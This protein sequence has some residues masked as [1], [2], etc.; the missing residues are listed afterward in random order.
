VVGVPFSLHPCQHLLFVV[1]L[2]I[3]ILTGVRWNLKVILICISF[4]ARDVQHFFM[5]FSAI[6]TSS[7]EKD[8][9]SSFVY[10]FIG[11][12]I[13]GSL[14]FWA[15]CIF[16][17]LNLCQMYNRQGFF[18][19]SVGSLF[20]LETILFVVQKLFNFIHLSIISL[21]WWAL[22][23]LFRKS[24][25]MP[26]NSNVF[27]ALFYTSFKVS[28]FMI[29]SLI[30]FELMLAQGESIGYSFSFLHADTQFSHY[31]IFDL[32]YLFKEPG[33]VL[34]SLCVFDLYF[35]NFRLYFYYFSPFASFEF[36]FC[37]PM[38][39]RWNIR[40]CIWDLSVFIIYA[41]MAINFPLRTA[42]AVSHRFW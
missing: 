1:F 36:S 27:P 30:H 18:S 4:M 9:F 40:L 37:L 11:S 17:L 2:M 10:F 41:L 19:H 3:A 31:M 23:V 21:C 6:W 39:I 20:N 26:I 35:I 5:D 22:W 14:V 13:F 25:S 42:F 16:W 7:F 12:L 33:F 15:P 32:I 24:L 34:L 38:S 8:M 28:G 29:R